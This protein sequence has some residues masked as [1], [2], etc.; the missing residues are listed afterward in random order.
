VQAS[1]VVCSDGVQTDETP[2]AVPKIQLAGSVR[3]MPGV[4][5]DAAGVLWFV[6]ADMTRQVVLKPGKGC[7]AKATTTADLSAY[8]T[9]AGAVPANVACQ[10]DALDFK[11]HQS[12]HLSLARAC[13]FRGSLST[14]RRFDKARPAPPARCGLWRFANAVR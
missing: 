9:A 8:P 5:T 14:R 7:L 13:T 11:F 4:A 10:Y 6:Q 1:E 3:T 12:V 2:P